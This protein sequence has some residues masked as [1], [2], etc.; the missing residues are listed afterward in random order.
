MRT[1][2]SYTTY[3]KFGFG[4]DPLFYIAI[5]QKVDTSP[6]EDPARI[7]EQERKTGTLLKAKIL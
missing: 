4:T 2:A 7:W 3:A 1:S 5:A 6:G